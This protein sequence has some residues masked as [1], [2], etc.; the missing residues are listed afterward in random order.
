MDE[1]QQ[2]A[3]SMATGGTAASGWHDLL[4]GLIFVAMFVWGA[5]M[6][7]TAYKGLQTGAV[8]FEQF[9]WVAVRYFVLYCVMTY[10]FLQA[11]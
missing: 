4:V 1:K 2:K 11:V 9:K 7:I 8:R 10:I 5:W 3:F 6:L